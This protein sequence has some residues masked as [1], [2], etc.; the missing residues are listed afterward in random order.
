EFLE[1]LERRSRAAFEREQAD[2]LAFRRE[3]EGQDAPALEP[4]D[5][6]YYAEKLRARLYA[7]DEEALRPYFSLENVLTGLFDLLG[8]LYGIRIERAER[9]PAWHESVRAYRVIDADESLLGVF[10]ADLFPREEKR[11]GAWMNA[12]ITAEP[13]AAGWSPHVGLICANV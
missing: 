1:D 8:K 4:W 11:G 13:S 5:V 2:L 9:M 6:A 12:F 3:L 10:Y 7:I